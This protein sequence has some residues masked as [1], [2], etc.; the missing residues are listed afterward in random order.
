MTKDKTQPEFAPTIFMST[1]HLASIESGDSEVIERTI[2]LIV[3]VHGVDEVWLRTGKGEMFS[4]NKDALNLE[5]VSL[6][7]SLGTEFKTCALK[8]INAL[9]DLQKSL[10]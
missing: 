8:Q 6:F 3:V 5:L 9:H 10:K 7:N 4:T 1:S 2:F